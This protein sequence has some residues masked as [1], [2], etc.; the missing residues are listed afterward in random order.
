MTSNE[1]RIIQ[2]HHNGG[3]HLTTEEKAAFSARK[4]FQDLGYNYLFD[5]GTYVYNNYFKIRRS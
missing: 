4:P 3:E 2:F 5:L 1:K